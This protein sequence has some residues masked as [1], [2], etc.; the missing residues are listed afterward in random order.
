MMLLI[1]VNHDIRLGNQTSAVH[2]IHFLPNAFILKA[3]L[4]L[5]LVSIDKKTKKITT[6]PP[7]EKKFPSEL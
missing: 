3:T 6:P 2:F 1:K 7:P 4:C 5:G